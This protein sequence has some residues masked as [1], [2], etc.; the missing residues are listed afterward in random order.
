LIVDT[1]DNEI[2]GSAT[3]SLVGHS[4]QKAKSPYGS[5]TSTSGMSD[6]FGLDVIVPQANDRR[7]VLDDQRNVSF[8]RY[9]CAAASAP[10][11]LYPSG[12]FERAM[13]PN[14]PLVGL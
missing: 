5:K 2:A 13:N 6:R 4:R 8:K 12:G 10:P 11:L 3:A 9:Y 1:T 7:I 14:A